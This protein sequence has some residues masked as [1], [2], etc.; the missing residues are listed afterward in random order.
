MHN[1][2]NKKSPPAQLNVLIINML[3]I[4]L[5]VMLFLISMLNN[6]SDNK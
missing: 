6:N 1:V 4:I 3:N 2:V 5:Y